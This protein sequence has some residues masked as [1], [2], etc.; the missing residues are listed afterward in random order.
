[1]SENVLPKIVCEIADI[2]DKAI[3]EHGYRLQNYPM[4]PSKDGSWSFLINP[5][6]GSYDRTKALE[7][8]AVAF[9]DNG[10]KGHKVGYVV[11]TRWVEPA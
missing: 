10:Y 4:V 11:G 1:M 2:I 3:N 8:L 6:S 7:A 5:S 9:P